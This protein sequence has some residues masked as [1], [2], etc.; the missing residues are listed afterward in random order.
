MEKYIRLA[1]GAAILGGICSFWL[2]GQ[3]NADDPD[4]KPDHQIYLP[5]VTTNDNARNVNNITANSIP[6]ALVN[7]TGGRIDNFTFFIPF[8]AD[9]LD[10]Q[11]EVGLSDTSPP[12]RPPSLLNNPI[13]MV[14]SIAVDREGSLIFYDHWEDGLEANLTQPT[15]SSTEIWG[16]DNPANGIPPGFTRDLLASAALPNDDVI[17]LRNTVELPRDPTF[18]C[19]VTR[20]FCA[21]GGDVLTSEGGAVAVS[22]TFWT[23]PPGPGPLFTDAWEL[24]PTNRWG[25]LYQI[26]IGENLAGTGPN[27][28]PGFEV[29]GLNVQAAEDNTEVQLD[30]NADGIFEETKILNEGEQWAKLGTEVGIGPES[31][32]VGAT[33]KSSA[34]VQVHVVAA[35]PQ[36][37]YEMRGFT[38]VPVDQLTND[39]LSPRSSDGDF[40]LY[41]PNPDN[42]AVRVETSIAA[43]T[44]IVITGNT[45]IKYPP[46]GLSS[47]TGIRFTATAQ[48]HSFYVL[49]AFD[50][51]DTQDWGY[52]VLPF[53]RLDT[54]SLVGLGLGNVN[55]PPDGDESPV[56]VTAARDTTI[57]VDYDNDGFDPTEDRAFAVSALEEQSITDVDHNLTGAFLFT[58]DNTP[59]ATV[60]GQRQDASPALP[61]ID[62][63]TGIVPLPS[64]LL[65]KTFRVS[66]DVDCNGTVN[67]GDTILFKL[68]YFNQ[69]VRPINNV[70]IVDDL[71]PSVSYLPHTTLLNGGPFP[72]N[73]SGTPFALDEGGYN[74]GLIGALGTG[75][76][77]FQV[78]I[79]QDGID[80]VNKADV[81][82]DELTLEDSVAIFTAR[83]AQPPLYRI[84]QT[85]TDPADG[86]ASNGEPVTFNLTIT[87]TSSVPITRFPLRYTFNP[88]HLIFR[89]AT[90]GVDNISP[91]QLDWND[92]TDMLG[93][94]E[95]G[96]ALS[97]TIRFRVRDDLPPSVTD[98]S[99]EAIGS[100][101][102]LSDGTILPICSAKALVSTQPEEF[103]TVTPTPSRT[104]MPTPTK[105]PDNPPPT[106]TPI[107]PPA[108]PIAYVPQVTATVFPVTFL[109]E[110]GAREAFSDKW[111]S[112]SG[113]VLLILGVIVAVG[114]YLGKKQR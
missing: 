97:L 106:S 103:P 18:S 99:S 100:G 63:G 80:I 25:T 101:G 32:L 37:R 53:N 78:T 24:Y 94:I 7:S 40:W 51:Q 93:D 28:R 35:N 114:S 74:L 20:V 39:Y 92:L 45:T 82:S 26:P 4:S 89:E 62:A 86:I 29:V 73:I 105:T 5:L 43:P 27:Q 109:P 49:A 36:S 30:L 54:Q 38:M 21:D 83:Q 70:V 85:L 110:T 57:F 111:T 47:A 72:D 79:R 108:T 1:L 14:I 34:P 90:P 112:I 56:Y 42:L 71:P 84:T 107:P 6:I 11:F 58:A 91:G 41:N 10:D 8:A 50:E 52:A 46:A 3:T 98:I 77:T 61:S 48:D 69:T 102:E 9:L 44:T 88:V 23:A 68:Q 66:D 59:F 96:A 15:Q 33:V 76:F 87:N 2:F 104:P 12:P 95:P 65:Q 31:V 75:V 16:D 13:V 60:W 22:I 81:R 64:L 55:V 19:G 113:R 17:T 67:I